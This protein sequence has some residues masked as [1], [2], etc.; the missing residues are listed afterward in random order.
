[1][2]LVNRL[3]VWSQ[4]FPPTLHTARIL[5]R[6]YMMTIPN[7]LIDA[8]RVDGAGQTTIFLCIILPV[9]SPVLSA[10]AIL[11]FLHVWNAY[12][13]PTLVATR[14]SVKPIMV[15]LLELVD[16]LIGFLPIY[17]TIMAGRVLATLP[18]AIVFF[19]F[20]DKFMSSVTIGAVK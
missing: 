12:L 4:D 18:L 9:C 13:W 10:Y 1:L 2:F 6:Q 7:E 8:A 5:I 14:D 17:G 20:E 11:H 19:I 3:T 16:P 15:A